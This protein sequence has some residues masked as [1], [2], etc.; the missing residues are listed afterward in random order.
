MDTRLERRIR[1]QFRR[2]VR[3]ARVQVAAHFTG[4]I[5]ILPPDALDARNFSTSREVNRRPSSAIFGGS[6]GGPLVRTRLSSR[7]LKVCGMPGL[8]LNSLYS[9]MRSARL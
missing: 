7:L 3:I 4:I 1:A 9:A 5:C 2:L 8:D 6:I